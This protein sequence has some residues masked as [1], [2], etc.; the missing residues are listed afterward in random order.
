L[1]IEL[2]TKLKDPVRRSWYAQ[3]TTVNGWSRPMLVQWIESDLYSR[4]GKAVTNFKKVLPAPQS[5]LA[6]AIV[7]D[8]YKFEFSDAPKRCS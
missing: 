5:D 8:P 7:R 4:Q 3:Q 2:I 1:P 6:D